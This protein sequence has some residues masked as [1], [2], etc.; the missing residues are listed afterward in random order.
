MGRTNYSVGFETSPTGGI[1]LDALATRLINSGTVNETLNSEQDTRID[2]NESNVAINTGKIGV[3]ETSNTAIHTKY[4]SLEQHITTI[5]SNIANVASYLSMNVD[6]I[7]ILEEFVGDVSLS[8][9]TQ[10]REFLE[11]NAASIT[12]LQHD[13]QTENI[14]ILNKFVEQGD[15]INGAYS[16]AGEVLDIVNSNVARLDSRINNISTGAGN[17]NTAIYSNTYNYEALGEPAWFGNLRLWDQSNVVIQPS[18]ES[19]I[20]YVGDVLYQFYN[21]GGDVN[22]L[23][24]DQLANGILD[25]TDVDDV[26][27]KYSNLLT[28]NTGL[29]NA[30]VAS[31]FNDNLTSLKSLGTGLSFTSG[32]NVI[33]VSNSEITNEAAKY[34]FEIQIAFDRGDIDSFDINA[35]FKDFYTSFGLFR[36]DTDFKATV[37]PEN[38]R[39]NINTIKFKVTKLDIPQG[40]LNN[41]TEYG[42]GVV[43]IDNTSSGGDIQ[44][45]YDR[46]Y[47]INSTYKEEVENEVQIVPLP[48]QNPQVPALAV[49]SNKYGDDDKVI[50]IVSS[51]KSRFSVTGSGKVDMRNGELRFGSATNDFED[52]KFGGFVPKLANVDAMFIQFPSQDANANV[53]HKEYFDEVL[54]EMD[55]ESGNIQ[56]VPGRTDEIINS[57]DFTDP[58]GQLVNSNIFVIS[59]DDG[60][61]SLSKG[62]R[63]E[64]GISDTTNEDRLKGY[65]NNVKLPVWVVYNYL[66]SNRIN[67]LNSRR[68]FINE[69]LSRVSATQFNDRETY[70]YQP[71]TGPLIYVFDV[72]VVDVPVFGD[73]ETNFYNDSLAS[74]LWKFYRLTPAEIKNRVKIVGTT[75]D[76]KTGDEYQI[77]PALEVTANHVSPLDPIFTVKSNYLGDDLP[78]FSVLGDGRLQGVT[79]IGTKDDRVNTIFMNS[80]LVFNERMTFSA[81]NEG[82]KV[83]QVDPDGSMLMGSNKKIN[84]NNQNGA[85]SFVTTLNNDVNQGV[86]PAETGLAD[87][88]VGGLIIGN[89]RLSEVGGELVVQKLNDSTK[90]YALDGVLRTA[91]IGVGPDYTVSTNANNHITVTA[92]DDQEILALVDDNNRSTTLG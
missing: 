67:R 35:N 65:S 34:G 20:N 51:G 26:L 38:G 42:G 21:N 17:A 66:L 41:F 92:I 40:V 29:V 62:T 14:Y 49:I 23:N 56:A 86:S 2:A 61:V 48:E 82:N 3:L 45:I 1:D 55:L 60:V 53:I 25:L 43:V 22:A 37:F 91:G 24:R 54:S 52:N 80:E 32:T 71:D 76:E 28:Y 64:T 85:M 39:L 87:I 72:P 30:N 44:V 31:S 11:S 46:Q 75:P 74:R 59:L 63:I 13:L 69:F 4:D 70:Y 68:L 77:P 8:N 9:V 12:T 89:Y 33:N 16:F 57:I 50:D 81:T 19:V 47:T 84:P 83:L 18:F 27:I 73:K 5:D 36:Y 7:Q 15:A 58:T 10:L 6:R 78:L 90:Q 88:Q 79:A